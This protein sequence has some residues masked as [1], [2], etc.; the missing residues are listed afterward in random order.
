MTNTQFK[1][2]AVDCSIYLGSVKLYPTEEPTPPA[3]SFDGKY[4]LTLNDGSVVSAECGSS[5]VIGTSEL[6]NYY[7]TAIEAEIGDCVTQLGDQC[8]AYPNLS[9]VTIGSGV[10]TI[11]NQTFARSSLSSVT[12]PSNVSSIGTFAFQET[13]LTSVTIEDGVTSIG[14]GAFQYCNNLSS[15]TIPSSVTSIG[16]YPL[17]GCSS[18]TSITVDSGNTVYDS[19]EDCNAI[20]ETSTNKLIQGCNT[21]TIPNTITNIGNYAFQN[22]TN[23]TSVVIP[24]GVT[25]VG[26]Y[27]FQYC[28]SL[29]S[30]TIPNS[31]TSIGLYAFNGDTSLESVTIGSNVTSINPYAFNGCTS[32]T[33]ITILATTPPTLNQYNFAFSG[34]NDCPIYVPCESVEAYKTAQY[35]SEY[36]SRIQGIDCHYIPSVQITTVNDWTYRSDDDGNVNFIL[37]TASST[38]NLTE[39]TLTISGITNITFTQNNAV[40]GSGLY[41]SSSLDN[42]ETHTATR[43]TSATWGLTNLDP[44]QTYQVKVRLLRKDGQYI[45]GTNASA[46]ITW[47]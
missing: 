31:V 9:S 16:N 23:I 2:G 37:K 22:C 7:S 33:S 41:Y 43:A 34:T 20:V 47:S 11:G 6:V 19:R 35:W 24:N 3:P 38:S 25:N 29:T 18:L 8:L 13:P 44:S 10:T 32:L 42:F 21:S 45:S 27:A 5:S 1:V 46:D 36:A 15:V 40:S 26:D 30:I 39:C 17:R 4:I 12:I 14:G 28:S